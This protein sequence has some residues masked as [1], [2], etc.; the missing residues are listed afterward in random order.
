MTNL[1]ASGNVI[2]DPMTADRNYKN[3]PNYEVFV[4]YYVVVPKDQNS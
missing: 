3:G 4:G 1:D 2:T